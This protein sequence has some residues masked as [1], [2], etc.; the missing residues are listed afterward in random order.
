MIRD[1]WTLVRKEIKEL[2]V[3]CLNR[4]GS[5]ALVLTL[6]MVF[7]V[8]APWLIGPDWLDGS[9]AFLVWIVLPIP[10]V[11]AAA[12]ESFAGERERHTLE[13]LLASPLSD[14][15]ILA[16]K[17][18]AAM[19][20]G[21]LV[22]LA[23]LL[24]GLITVNLAH[25]GAPVLLYSP[26]LGMGSVGLGLLTSLLTACAGVIVSLRVATVRQAK[27]T[28][29]LLLVLVGFGFVAIGA[30]LLHFLPNDLQFRLLTGVSA[31][32]LPPLLAVLALALM[33]TDVVLYLTAS[34][35]FRRT[36]LLAD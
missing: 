22:S 26:A 36:Q 15:A 14:Q 11:I 21:W 23:V 3:G 29:S 13:T 2:I 4:A 8:I 27:W 6:A 17:I 1:I 24:L 10:L 33:T 16:G 5:L 30:V 18:I 12:A 9:L 35:R 19:L 20:Y 7:G 28:L 25:T 31:S 32:A 34:A